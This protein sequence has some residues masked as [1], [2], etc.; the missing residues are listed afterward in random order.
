MRVA[1]AAGRADVARTAQ[2]RV[3]DR[4]ARTPRDEVVAQRAQRGRRTLGRP[5]T[6]SATATRERRDAARRRACRTARRAPARR[7]AARASASSPRRASSAPTPPGPPTLCPLTVIASSPDA[8]KSTGTWPDGLHRVGVHGDAVPARERDDVVERLQRAR[9]RCSPTS[10]EISATSSPCAASSSRSASTSSTPVGVDRQEHQ[11]GARVLGHPERRV[12]HRVVLDGGDQDPASAR[13]LRC[14]APQ[15]MPLIAR[16][17]ASVPPDGPDDLARAAR[18]GPRRALA[19][20]LDDPTRRATGRVQRRGVAGA[21]ELLGEHPRGLR[22]HGRGRRMVEIH[23][24]RLQSTNGRG[25]QTR[26]AGPWDH[27][28]RAP[29]ELA[30]CA[31]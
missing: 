27:P 26:A 9:P 22:E 5:A 17:S 13:V 25:G 30:G 3:G 31:A 14:V 4:G 20:L 15:N 18:R 28:P 16:L 19:R 12:E 11:L 7:R 6:A 29:R 10:R 24:H 1:R 21:H 23:A 8:P 2:H